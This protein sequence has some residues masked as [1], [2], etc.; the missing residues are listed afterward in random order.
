MFCFF[1]LFSLLIEKYFEVKVLNCLTA[2]LLLVF[3]PLQT[4][5]LVLGRLRSFSEA[6]PS[7]LKDREVLVVHPF[8]LSSRRMWKVL[9]H[10]LKCHCISGA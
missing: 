2:G 10:L 4:S 1:F 3:S 6:L 5:Q 9:K 8:S 7:L